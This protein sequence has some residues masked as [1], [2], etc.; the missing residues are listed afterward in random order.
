MAGACGQALSHHKTEFVMPWLDAVMSHGQCEA[1]D[2]RL[3]NLMSIGKTCLS[4]LLKQVCLTARHSTCQ[5][6]VECFTLPMSDRFDVTS[7]GCHFLLQ[8]L[9]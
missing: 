2:S 7:W 3:I 4:C 5:S 6:A 9:S 8:P 1:L